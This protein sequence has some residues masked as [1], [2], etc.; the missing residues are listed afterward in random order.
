M[1]GRIVQLI[2]I[3]VSVAIAGV[4]DSN[5]TAPK[6]I[7]ILYGRK[8][9]DVRLIRVSSLT[10]VWL[11]ASTKAPTWIQAGMTGTILNP[12][13]YVE[14][15][16]DGKQIAIKRWPVPVASVAHIRL[17]HVAGRWRV[18]ING[19]RSVWVRLRHAI[20]ITVLETDGPAQAIIDGKLVS[21]G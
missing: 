5:K 21:G 4:P 12:E 7:S 16:R 8:T 15:G 13:I 20:S 14:R 6:Y 17:R 3:V 1:P 2:V 18:I 10:A 19:Y 9:A 11:G